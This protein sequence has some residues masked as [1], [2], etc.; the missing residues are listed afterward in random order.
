MNRK[1]RFA[2]LTTKSKICFL[3]LNSVG[4]SSLLSLLKGRNISDEI[5]PTVGLE[6]ENSILNGKKVNIWDF[7]GQERYHFMWQDFLR[8]AGLAVLVCDSTEENIEKTKEI[9]KKAIMHKGYALVDIFQPC[10]TFNRINTYKWFKENTYYLEDSHD[11][12]NKIEAFK[13][14]TEKNKLP[15]GVFY[16]NPHK[17]SFEDS[18]STYQEN[19]EPLYKRKLNLDKLNK[20][21]D[22][23]RKS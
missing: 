2:V 20:L 8:G 15:L 5:D 17:N 11:P 9:L 14:A 12:Y 22:S 10:V 21:I 1:G 7:G 19:K 16:I 3:G 4:K 13:R 23:K 18:I 6:I